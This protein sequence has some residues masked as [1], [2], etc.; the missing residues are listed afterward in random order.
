V[1]AATLQ[2]LNAAQAIRDAAFCARSTK[3]G[4]M[5]ACATFPAFL[6]DHCVQ[7]KHATTSD[8]AK[9]TAEYYLT[10]IFHPN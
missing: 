5:F 4:K 6:F 7:H 8:K 1:L 3:T 2:T 9:Q 10:I